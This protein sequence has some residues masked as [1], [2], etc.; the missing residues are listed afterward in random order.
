MSLAAVARKDFRD[1]VRSR[2]LWALSVLFVLFAAG[3]A[4]AFT[5]IP[6]LGSVPGEVTTLGLL[7]F[8]LG[9]AGFF[10]PVIGMMI[11]YK[12]IV[13]ERETGQL[14]LL[15]SLPHSRSDAVVGKVL[16]RSLSLSVGVLVGFAVAVVIVIARVAEFDPTAYVLFVLLTL[17]FGVVYVSIG[18]GISS[19]TASSSKALALAILFLAAFEFLWGLVILA[20]RF[21]AN[22]FSLSFQ[23]LAEPPEWARFLGVLS[24][25]DA[26]G[27]AAGALIPDLSEV[28]ASVGSENAPEAFYLQDWFGLVVLAFWMT[29][30]LVLGYLRF[31]STDLT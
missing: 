7:S 20:L 25:G 14:K 29:V 27:N 17:V 4:Y 5:A 23:Q 3:L 18:V 13:G 9:P 2:W 11:G 30:P 16:G 21:V 6:G 28:Q 15:L 12:A 10:V 22:G 26:Y 8:L 31:R 24:P 19:L 1:S